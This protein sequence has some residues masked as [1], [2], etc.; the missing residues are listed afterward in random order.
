MHPPAP[1]TIK[2]FAHRHE[3][4]HEITAVSSL[5]RRTM[6]AVPNYRLMRA[7]TQ[8]DATAASRLLLVHLIGYLGPDDAERPE[9]RFV[10][11][12]GNTRLSDELRCTPRSIQ[13]QADELESK[14]F[15]RRC[16]NA[17]NRRTGFDLTPFALQ[18]ETIVAEI[19]GVHTRRRQE[20]DAAQMELTLEADRIERPATSA[21]S[22]GDADVAHNRTGRNRSV[23]AAFAALDAF[24]RRPDLATDVLLPCEEDRTLDER[25]SALADVTARF[26]SG[27]RAA[28]MGWSA[29]LQSLGCE[30]ALALHAVASG[31]P[32]RRQSPERYFG[33]LLRMISE[34]DGSPLVAAAERAAARPA[35]APRAPAPQ[36]S[37]GSLVAGIL[38]DRASDAAPKAPAAHRPAANDVP[39]AALPADHLRPRLR[40]AVGD[41][42]YDTWLSK[43]EI[44]EGAGG[45]TITARTPFAAGWIERNLVDKLGE[46]L[47]RE[48]LRVRS[49]GA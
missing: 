36:G 40:G 11:F 12:P 2:G 26:A 41:R 3:T 29:A 5:G 33:W 19:V 9:S 37:I 17:M 43:A 24:D 8:I 44:D 18:H 27:G 13:R 21:S 6:S 14:G 1:E 46:A 25:N 45:L 32:R 31:D 35:E 4:W 16:Y 20:R 10:V 28:T 23:E 49:A 48:D 47:G 30:R 22:Q 42:V 34:G 39:A 38:G 7:A 15:L